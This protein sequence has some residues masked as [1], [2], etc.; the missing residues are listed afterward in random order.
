MLLL[1]L[2]LSSRRRFS[3][4]LSIPLDFALFRF[5]LA[6]QRL[7][8]IDDR[9]LSLDEYLVASDKQPGREAGR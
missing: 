8:T 6:F 4:L 5:L 3:F 7:S 9:P 1:S 2:S